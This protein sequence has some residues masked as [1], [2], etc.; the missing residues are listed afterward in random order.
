MRGRPMKEKPR[1]KQNCHTDCCGDEPVVVKAKLRAVKIAKA[2]KARKGTGS[3]ETHPDHSNELRRLN[4]ILGQLD[5]ISRMISDGRYC[6][7]ILVQTR[8]AV[9]AIKALETSIL[10]RHLRMCVRSAFNSKKQEDVNTKIGELLDL[11]K[12]NGGD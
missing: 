5:G 6:T 2:T 10:N 7:D 12:A 9:A 8:A 4:R 3:E 1:G 11:F